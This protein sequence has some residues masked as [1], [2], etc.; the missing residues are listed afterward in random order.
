MTEALDT[1][2]ND[3]LTQILLRYYR[4]A[5]ALDVQRPEV[6]R[7]QDLEL[8]RQHWAISEPVRKLVECLRENPQQLQAVLEARLR[9]DDARIHGRFDARA[10]AIRRLVT[11]HPTTIVS[12]EP[13]RTYD[14]GPNHVLSWVLETAW[15]LLGR[16]RECVPEG[17]SYQDLIGAC[18]PGLEAVR[19]F[20]AMHQ[21]AKIPTV[22]RRPS[23][24]SVKEASRSRR[25]IYVLASLAYRHL[26][27]VEAG[28]AAALLDLLNDTLLGPLHA[29][30]RFELAVGLGIARALST[31][32]DQAVELGFFLGG[33]EPI[34]R[35][36]RYGIYWQA[37]TE[38]YQTPTQEPS[39]TRTS[40]LLQAYGILEGTDRPD[41][42]VTD[43]HVPGEAIAVVE[44]KYYSSG[45]NDGVESVR[46]A[47]AQLVR[48]ARG[49]REM[50]N[51][52][53]IL[54][55]SIIGLARIE[56][57]LKSKEKPYGIPLLIDFDA[58]TN[59]ALV[60]WARRLLIQREGA[61]AA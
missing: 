31:A 59:E 26:L 56:G 34:A 29:W 28:E 52:E 55:H 20:D 27:Q 44:V 57:N 41:L 15:R 43:E 47:A 8:L 54:D 25:P 6:N 32:R 1:A 33:G 17:A 36:G 58:I 51:I 10:T 16:F 9:E 18:A 50:K 21:V 53:T 45:D 40:T 61:V 13:R 4:N 11:G 3:Y 7:N 5:T 35:V 49:Y 38:H 14:S 12:H 22:G 60:Q 37:R 23:A 48:Y 2:V 39:E 42:V 46:A 19:R 24:Q 30:Q